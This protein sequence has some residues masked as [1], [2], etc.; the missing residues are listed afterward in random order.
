MTDGNATITAVFP[1][2]TEFDNVSMTLDINGEKMTFDLEDFFNNAG[3][4]IASIPGL[5]NMKVYLDGKEISLIDVQEI[6]S[7]QIASMSVDKKENII[8]I[9]IKKTDK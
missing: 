5:E 8:Y 9:T 4:S 1:F 3:K 7:D 2:L 6:A